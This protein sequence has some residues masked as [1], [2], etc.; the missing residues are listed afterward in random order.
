MLIIE[1]YV[2]FINHIVTI[3]SE[4]GKIIAKGSWCGGFELDRQT[5]ATSLYEVI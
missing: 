4:F 1:F 2:H 5:K 3:L